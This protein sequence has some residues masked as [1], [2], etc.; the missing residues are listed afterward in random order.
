MTQPTCIHSLQVSRATAPSLNHFPQHPER[1]V[2][3]TDVLG[4]Y[5]ANR[6]EALFQGLRSAALCATRPLA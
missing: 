2:P 5:Y 6:D 1:E 3:T 4:E